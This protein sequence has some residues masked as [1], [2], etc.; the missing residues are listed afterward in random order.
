MAQHPNIL[1][2]LT[3]DQR[4]DTIHALGNTYIHTP[5][6]D[7]LVKH[8]AAFTNAY[9]MGGTSGAVCMPSRAMLWTGRTLFHI[10]EQGQ[11]IASEHIMLGETLQRAGY[12]V[13]GTGKWHNGPAAHGRNFNA[14]AEI[15]YGGMDDHWNMPVCDFDPAGEYPQRIHQTVDFVTQRVAEKVA[16]HIHA[17]RHSSVLF[18][19]AAIDFLRGRSSPDPFFI[20]VGFTAPHDPRTM[21]RHYLEMYDDSR[22]G[23]TPPLPENFLPR[24]PFDN[25]EMQVRDELLAAYPRDPHEV[26]RH[27]AAYYGMITHL[28]A[29]IGRV[30]AALREAGQLDNT[31]VVLAGD[32]GLALGRH[33]LMGKQSL[34]EHSIHVPLLMCGP[35]IAAGQRSDVFVYLNDIYPTLCDLL[36]L[37]APGSVEGVSFAASLSRDEGRKTKSAGSG[38]RPGQRGVLSQTEPGSRDHLLFA[39]RHLMR[40]VRDERWKLIE[41]V[42]DNRRHTQLFDLQVDPWELTNLAGEPAH[43]EH[44]A[45]L[46]SLLAHWR[47][48]LGD[49]QEG[50]GKMFWD[51]Y[52]SPDRG[53][54]S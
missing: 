2:F 3:D 1:F 4:F 20:Y 33:G 53:A 30:L 10:Q 43:D 14:G 13:F 25:G 51:G 22:G 7:W 15:F 24:H 44:L 35:G 8:G 39:Y 52:F 37:T 32:N 38:R 42:V 49:T 12:T 50:L 41:Y 34:Y 31:L 18:C 23:V 5:N 6:L 54:G 27:L 9:I 16:D 46:R 26:C 28:D 48:E 19:D 21:P 29:Q 47:D 11:G 40:G 45:R 17:G 36:G